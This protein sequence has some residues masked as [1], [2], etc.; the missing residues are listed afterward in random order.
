MGPNV[1]DTYIMLKPRE[2]WTEGER[3]RRAGRGDRE[4][5]RATLPGR[6]TS[7]AS[8]SSCAST[9]SSAACAATSRSRC[10]ATTST[11]MLAR[12]TE[13]ARAASSVPGVADVKVEQVEGLP[14]LT[15]DVDRDAIA[16]YG[17]NV[18]DVQA[19]RREAAMGGVEAGR[20]SRAT[21]ASTSSCA[22]PTRSGGLEALEAPPD[23]AARRARRR[24]LGR[25]RRPGALRR[26]A[27][28]PLAKISGR[29]GTEPGQPRER[30]ASGRRPGNVRGRDLG[31]FVAEA[32]GRID[33]EIKLPP[34]YWLAWGGQF[35][36]LIAARAPRDRGAGRARADLRPALRR[37][38][39]SRT[40]C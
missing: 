25:A 1:S 15:I 36:N 21:A 8:R 4:G 31:G 19:G 14:V 38:A 16:R 17:L 20:C 7:S 2:E 5:R 35:E 32:Q 18:D 27:R 22:C 23:P 10:S 28:L 12:R 33:A 39:A 40:R 30:Q 13:I 37:S 26:A 29:G 6:T 9:S 34:G 11:Q 3:R 24:A